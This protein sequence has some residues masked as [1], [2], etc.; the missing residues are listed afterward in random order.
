LSE[1]VGPEWLG[2]LAALPL[3]DVSSEGAPD[4]LAVLGGPEPFREAL[5]FGEPEPAPVTPPAPDPHVE[6]LKRAR[7]EGEAAG[8]AAAAAEAADSAARQRAL[9]LNF[10]SLDEAALAVL[11]EDLAATVMALA[12][13]VLGEA[14]ID[15]AGLIAR[16]HAAA[17]RIGGAA[18]ALALHLHPED[19]DLIGPEALAGWRV[20]PDAGVTR[21]ALR[22]EGPE[23][24]V[25][26][27]PEEWRR[28]IAAAVRE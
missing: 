13:G 10:R 18:E 26:D 22:I 28:A 27:G 19:I 23:G 16:C 11:A 12:E 4:W 3:A 17:R 7:A 21:G 9:R 25:S 1:R 15:R 8:R 20:V 6:A 14:A 24:A 5:P 2:E